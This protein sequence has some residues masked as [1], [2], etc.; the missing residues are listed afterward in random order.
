MTD[1]FKEVLN[2]PDCKFSKDG[3]ELKIC[4]KHALTPDNY[5]KFLPSNI[6]K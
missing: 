2:C 6:W 3:Q 1:W 4:E 5:N